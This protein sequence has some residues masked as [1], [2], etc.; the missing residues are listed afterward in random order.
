MP[1]LTVGGKGNLTQ[2]EK[3][4]FFFLQVWVLCV[5]SRF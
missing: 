2:E 1:P 4:L 3:A 5:Y